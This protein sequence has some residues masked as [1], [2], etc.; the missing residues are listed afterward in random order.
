MFVDGSQCLKDF[1]TTATRQSFPQPELRRILVA[2]PPSSRESAGG[3]GAMSRTRLWSFGGQSRKPANVAIHT[4]TADDGNQPSLCA[5]TKKG[6]VSTKVGQSSLHWS[7]HNASIATTS[8][9]QYCFT[10]TP[11]RHRLDCSVFCDR[12]LQCEHRF[13]TVFLEQRCT[14]CKTR[15]FF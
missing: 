4:G 6:D 1:A 7:R 10:V 9:P 15:S 8:C 5:A 2:A 14:V 11:L 3:Y 13:A 12:S